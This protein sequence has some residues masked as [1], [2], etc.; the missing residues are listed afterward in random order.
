MYDILDYSYQRA[1]ELGYV[2][3]PSVKKNKKIDVFRDGVRV[4]S[5]GD[6]KYSDYPHYILSHG[7]SYANER[8]RLYHIRHKKEGL[9]G[10]LAKYILW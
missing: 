3:K 2:I 10:T 8:R 6:I 7:L 9:T 4:A 1:K 5:I